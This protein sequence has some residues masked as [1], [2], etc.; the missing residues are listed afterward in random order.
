MKT[1]VLN[2]KNNSAF[3]TTQ[4]TGQTT[5]DSALWV[6]EAMLNYDYGSAGKIETNVDTFHYSITINNS[7]TYANINSAYMLIAN[8]I[9]NYL[10]ININERV[11]LIDIYAAENNSILTIESEI[12]YTSNNL[13]FKTT[14]VCDPFTTEI[15]SPGLGTNPTLNGFNYLTNC[16]GNPTLDGKTLLKNK[17][18]G[19]PSY[20]VSCLLFNNEYYLTNMAIRLSHIDL[21]NKN[22]LI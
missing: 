5:K 21:I 6:L 12:I 15:A 19:C 1:K 16:S 22:R 3:K 14:G 2:P 4:T 11:K 10:S 13:G 8:K 7:V 20:T 18:N 17:L 9:N